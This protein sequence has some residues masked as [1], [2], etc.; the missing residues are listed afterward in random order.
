MKMLWEKTSMF[1]LEIIV[2]D[3]AV[4]YQRENNRF[5]MQVL[6]KIG[7]HQEILQQL[8]WV[9]VFMQVLFLSDILTT[10]GQKIN[11]KVLSCH[12]LGKAWS[13]MHWPNECPT[14]SDFQLWW[15]AML[16]MCLSRCLLT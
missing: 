16:V 12:Q 15:G 11:P 4:V 3:F 1:G 5:I 7:Y 14:K 2:T 6:F 8:N 10:P 9:C 13:C